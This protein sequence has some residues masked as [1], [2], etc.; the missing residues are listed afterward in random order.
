VTVGCLG[1]VLG[2][3]GPI[4]EQVHGESVEIAVD[5]FLDI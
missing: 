5:R 2:G 1:E 4:D 3:E